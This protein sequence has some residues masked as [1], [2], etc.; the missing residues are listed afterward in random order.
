[1][2]GITLNAIMAIIISALRHN[3][4][5]YDNIQHNGTQHNDKQHNYQHNDNDHNNVQL[6]KEIFSLE[7]TISPLVY[8]LMLSIMLLSVVMLSTLMMIAIIL[9]VLLLIHC[10]MLCKRASCY[11]PSLGWVALRLM[12]FWQSSLVH[13]GITMLSMISP[14]ITTL[15]LMTNS[16]IFSIMTMTVTTFNW[17][18]RYLA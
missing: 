13:S 12:P 8:V 14:T 18:K 15:N 2:S 17:K 1:M 6:K 5:Q 4:A 9:G 3:Y 10:S 16:K 7:W 11:W